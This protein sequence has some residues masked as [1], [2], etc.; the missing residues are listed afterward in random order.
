MMRGV[1][2]FVDRRLDPTTVVVWLLVFGGI[3][4]VTRNLAL[5]AGLLTAVVVTEAV[6]VLDTHP[7]VDERWVK[8]GLSGVLLMASSVW[9]YG[10]FETPPADRTLWLPAVAIVGSLW[11]VL[12]A[13]A[14][15]VEGRQFADPEAV[16]D[17]DSG[18]AM[19]VLQHI[20]L[21][22]RS[23]AEEPKTVEELAVDCDL[24]VS[25]VHE[26][27]ELG[28]RDDTIYPIDPAADEPRYALDDR[29]VGTSGVG[30]LAAGG[31]SRL[32]GRLLRPFVGLF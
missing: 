8:V 22:A 28:S 30:R 3:Y 11:V 17:L 12:D 16:D 18:E 25:R 24:T 26:A 10:E 1:R 6:D 13:R 14:D 9:L 21:V 7:D 32:F 15:F 4:A 5:L 23:L 31:L 27:I 2:R 19:V 29:K 20:Q